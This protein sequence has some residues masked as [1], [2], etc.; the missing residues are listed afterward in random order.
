MRETLRCVDRND[1]VASYRSTLAACTVPAFGRVLEDV[2]G[3]SL[4]PN[5][6]LAYHPR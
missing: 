1:D 4:R 3:S 6:D 5:G 2:R